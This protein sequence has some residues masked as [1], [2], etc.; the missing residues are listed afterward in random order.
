MWQALTWLLSPQK[1]QKCVANTARCIHSY[2]KRH[3]FMPRHAP[4]P[5]F[6][7]ANVDFYKRKFLERILMI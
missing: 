6:F 1:A 3:A 4:T 7:P 5:R 2:N